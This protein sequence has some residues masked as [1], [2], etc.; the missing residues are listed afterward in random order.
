ML[1]YETKR[2]ENLIS[3]DDAIIHFITND[4]I[5]SLESKNRFRKYVKYLDKL[6]KLK[7]KEQKNI[8][9]TLIKIKEQLISEN[10]ILEKAWLLEKLSEMSKSA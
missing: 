9:L 5:L 7:T 8:D 6:I 10:E 2:F 3:E 4:K 1:Y